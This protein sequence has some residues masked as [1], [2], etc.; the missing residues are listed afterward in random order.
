MSMGL[1]RSLT[2]LGTLCAVAGLGAEAKRLYMTGSFTVYIDGQPA[3][4]VSEASGGGISATVT[5]LGKDQAKGAYPNKR[6][7]T[8]TYDPIEFATGAGMDKVLYT[9]IRDTLAGGQPIPKNGHFST[10]SYDGKEQSRTTWTDGFLSEITFPE[11]D[12][13]SKEDAKIQLTITPAKTEHLPGSGGIEKTTPAKFQRVPVT[14]FRCRIG[15]IDPSRVARVESL[16][17][18]FK[19]PTRQPGELRLP[20]RG[21]TQALVE[22]S[23]LV[24]YVS[25]A[26]AEPARKWHEDFIVKGNNGDEKE[27][28][29]TI[30]LVGANGKDTIMTLTLKGVGILKVE[31]E[32]SGAEAAKDAVRRLRVEAYV[33]SIAFDMPLQPK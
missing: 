16:S 10:L 32:S 19:S 25:Q 29:G 9:W 11:L 26:N 2:W 30:E 8:L 5:V 21:A 18:R 24:F 28:E 23:N 22:V 1:G 12:A 15:D 3:A 4:H 31:P 20:A 13:A 14:S 7:G 6:V 33:E 27:K 17:V